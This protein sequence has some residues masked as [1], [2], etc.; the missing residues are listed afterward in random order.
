MIEKKWG[1]NNCHLKNID[2]WLFGG[3]FVWSHCSNQ[4]FSSCPN[5]EN[6][7]NIHKRWRGNPLPDWHARTILGT[8]NKCEWGQSL[9]MYW[10]TGGG[11]GSRET[12]SQCRTVWQSSESSGQNRHILSLCWPPIS[13]NASK[14]NFQFRRLMLNSNQSINR[15]NAV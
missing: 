5:M 1:I 15:K 14:V 8:Y 13:L 12:A 6:N 7:S 9:A 3:V 11:R 10:M 4:S 2:W